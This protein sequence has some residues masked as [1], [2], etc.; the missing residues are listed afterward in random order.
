MEGVIH[1]FRLVRYFSVASLVAI[2]ATMLVLVWFYRQLAI[3]GISQLAE[4]GNLV[5]ARTAL[6]PMKPM[7]LDH[8][9]ATDH[10]RPDSLVRQPLPPALAYAIRNLLVDKAVVR[11]KL[12][13]RHGTV[14]YSNQHLQVGSDQRNNP[15]FNA[16]VR[17]R[18]AN[19]LVYRDSFNKFDGG[20]E[21]DN[22][23]HTYLP[24]RDGPNGPVQGVFEI[25]TDVNHLA[26]QTE[27]T[28]FMIIL[29]ALIILSATY[30]V[31]VLIAWRAGNIIDRQ[32]ATIRERTSTLEVLSA[33]MLLSDESHKKKIAFDLHEGLAQTLSAIK[34]H[35]E[36]LNTHGKNDRT[37][38]QSIDAIIPIL[39]DAI[40]DVRTIA[41][42]LRPSSIDDFGLLPTLQLL[43]RKFEQQHPSVKIEQQIPLQEKDI[44]VQLKI[45]LY[46]IVESVLDDMTRYTDTGL[47]AL[48]VWRDGNVLNLMIDDTAA[49]VLDSTSIP[50]ANIN[51]QLSKGFA[52]MEELATLSGGTFSASHHAG[53]GATLHASW[54][55]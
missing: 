33:H 41:S 32:Q 23:M 46:R 28:E 29:A 35:I 15:G 37:D 7:L 36:N 8:L 50:L 30:G 47:I 40:Q 45:I 9:R 10:L 39:R 14:V 52:R 19:D 38:G 55:I 43:C 22:L 42:E 24:I 16:A 44:P 4:R 17:G 18:D 49:G 21:D 3:E 25:Y 34:L 12:L 31:V 20:T 5:L 53:R 48:S 54:N 26:H 27:R 13:N 1:M 51:P 11:V 6:A 2:L